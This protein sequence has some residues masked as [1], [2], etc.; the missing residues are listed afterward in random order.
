[1]DLD[2]KREGAAC[3]TTLL[4]AFAAPGDYLFFLLLQIVVELPLLNEFFE[5]TDL[6]EG[7]L[8]M[9]QSQENI[10]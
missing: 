4:Q 7:H 6:L 2:E 3:C 8:R 1:M 5:F 9:G 10:L